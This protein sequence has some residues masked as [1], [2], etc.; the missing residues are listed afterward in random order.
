MRTTCA[1]VFAAS[2]LFCPWLGQAASS[3]WKV[4]K[5]KDVVYVAGTVH[6]LPAD[7]FPLPAEFE[8]AYQ[9]ADVLVLEA[10]V[11]APDDAQAGLRMMQQLS[12]PDGS[13]LKQKLTPQVYQALADYLQPFGVDLAQLDRFKPGFIAM[14]LAILEMHK[15]GINGEGVDA[16]FAKK[17]KTDGKTTLFLETLDFQLSLM[18]GL[19]EGDESEFIR[20]NLANASDAAE[21]LKNSLLAW[22]Q[23]DMAT[24]EQLLLK[25]ARA[26]DAKTYQQMFTARNQQWLPKI[27]AM[28]GNSATELVM[29]GAG[30]LP[31]DDGV[32]RLLQQAGYQVEPL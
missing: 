6:L 18:A 12:Y 3:V 1:A 11:P 16:F 30:H 19:G 21:L 26:E 15:A 13:S 17:A 9:A 14:Q 25:K 31:G 8:R 7:Q 5:G 24:I 27:S 23:G 10:D 32:L 29:V 2:L 28:F 22:R 20:V 4:S